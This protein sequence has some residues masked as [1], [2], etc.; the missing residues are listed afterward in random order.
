LQS[1]AN[2]VLG[3]EAESKKLMGIFSGIENA[4]HTFAAWCE[5]ELTALH[6]EAPKLE[7]IA[8]TTLKYASGA[9]KIAASVEANNPAIAKITSV[10]TTAQNSVTAASGLIADFGATPTAANMLSSVSSNLS[11][12]LAAAHISNPKSVA[13]VTKVV[14]ETNALVAAVNLAA[15]AT[16]AAQAATA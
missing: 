11:E 13:A 6:N 12:L 4:E 8:D 16:E 7:Q 15:S 9:L 1:H 10:L 14:G 3:R 5:K 2:Q